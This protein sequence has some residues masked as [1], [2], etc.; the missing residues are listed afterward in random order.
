M[1]IIR[2]NLSDPSRLALIR[3]RIND[4]VA[5]TNLNRELGAISA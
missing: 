4:L 2:Q 5:K 3:E 1:N